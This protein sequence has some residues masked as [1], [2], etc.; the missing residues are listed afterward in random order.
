MDLHGVWDKTGS[1]IVQN[2]VHPTPHNIR[3]IPLP[4]RPS[5]ILELYNRS[6]DVPELHKILGSTDDFEALKL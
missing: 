3:K 5:T 6:C 1:T 2:R 4:M